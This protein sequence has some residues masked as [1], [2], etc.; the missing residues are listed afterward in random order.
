MNRPICNQCNQR[1]VAINYKRNGKTY[2]RKQC[3][4]CIRSKKK[5]KPAKPNWT[6][7]GYKKKLV[8]DKCGFKARWHSQL[9]V[10]YSDGDLT[11]T[12]LI[13]LKTICLNCTVVIEKGDMPW[14]KEIS[15]DF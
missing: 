12:K 5:I 11:N 14:A 3:D 7:V 8:C 13:N 10:Y 15:P 9:V 4:S 2:F 6:K 1:H